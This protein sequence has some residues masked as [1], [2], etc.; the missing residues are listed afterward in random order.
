GSSQYQ[1]RKRRPVYELP[2]ALASS[3]SLH[4]SSGLLECETKER[5]TIWHADSNLAKN[6]LPLYNSFFPELIQIQTHLEDFS[7]CEKHYNQ[8]IVS[9]FLRQQ[10]RTEHAY[11]IEV[12]KNTCEIGIQTDEFSNKNTRD[13]GIQ[14]TD[15][16]S[17][18][19]E[20]YINILQTQLSIKMNEIEN[21]QKQLDYAYDYVIE[22]WER[23]QEINKINKELSDQNNALKYCWENRYNNQKKRIDSIVQIANYERQNCKKCNTTNI[24]NKKRTCPNCNKKLDTLAALQAESANELIQLLI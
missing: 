19:L 2:C 23:I 13:I 20:N 15:N 3:V 6:R 1:Q 9:D 8:L 11:K 17:H 5:Q 12:E 24:D 22:S 4:D 10:A 7:L 14:V 18:T 16:M 21:L